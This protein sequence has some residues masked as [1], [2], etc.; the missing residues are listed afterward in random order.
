MGRLLYYLPSGH[1]T[2][3]HIPHLSLPVSL[4]CV[5]SHKRSLLF[6]PAIPSPLLSP[7]FHPSWRFVFGF[8]SFFFLFPPL[9]HRCSV[10]F[11]PLPLLCARVHLL[12]SLVSLSSSPPPPPPLFL[13]SPL[14]GC[15][16]SSSSPSSPPADACLSR[17]N[18][19]YPSLRALSSIR[20]AYLAV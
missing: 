1:R 16:F 9:C 8:F 4:F 15:V 10:S 6:S 14:L 19:F 5:V 12:L 7:F 20:C 13:L 11:T 18:L 3:S 2:E 17:G